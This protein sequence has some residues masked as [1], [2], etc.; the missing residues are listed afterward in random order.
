MRIKKK[1]TC[2]NLHSTSLS[3]NTSSLSQYIYDIMIT[4]EENCFL[5]MD[6]SLLESRSLSLVELRVDSISFIRLLSSLC[7][8]RGD[9]PAPT[10]T[11]PH[12]QNNLA[13]FSLLRD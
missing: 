11:L 7:Y 4:K 8:Q 6:L 3:W 13:L 5:R 2:K 1:L 9:R 12:Q 10:N